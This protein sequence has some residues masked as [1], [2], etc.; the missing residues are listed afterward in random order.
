M[1]TNKEDVCQTISTEYG[2][3]D[4]SVLI[5]FCV[6]QI[7]DRFVSI[8]SLCMVGGFNTGLLLP[9]V[10][11]SFRQSSVFACGTHGR[12]QWWHT[13]ICCFSILG[14]FWFCSTPLDLMSKTELTL[15]FALK[16]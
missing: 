2:S 4:I 7:E 9:S 8:Q 10:S 16:Q 1:M 14:T 11:E 3:E 12:C 6:K 13:Q 15:Q 5:V